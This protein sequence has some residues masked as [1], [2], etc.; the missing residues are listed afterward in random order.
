MGWLHR[1]RGR[2]RD[3]IGG[4]S[5]GHVNGRLAALWGEGGG[6]TSVASRHNEGLRMV[7]W[8]WG[9]DG[10]LSCSSPPYI[11]TLRGRSRWRQDDDITVRV[12][13]RVAARATNAS[14]ST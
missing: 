9:Y 1:V 3:E 7:E 2:S 8:W 5:L 13:E 11:R 6:R 14:R 12:L 4:G 10:A